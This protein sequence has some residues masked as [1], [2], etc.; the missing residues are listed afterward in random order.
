MKKITKQTTVREILQQV[1]TELGRS[2]A[3]NIWVNALMREYKNQVITEGGE[4]TAS[5][6][7]YYSKPNYKSYP[8]WIITDTRFPNELEAI[9]KR[10]GICIKITRPTSETPL[11]EHTSETSLD[12]IPD[13]DW[14]YIIH[15]DGSITD[16]I[17]KVREIL[18][19]ENIL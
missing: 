7:G 3:D 2:L 8:N 9:K 13:S 19:R 5:D 10:K 4:A 15:N 16:L 11:S 18:L 14:N 17:E 12:H 6:G 1:G